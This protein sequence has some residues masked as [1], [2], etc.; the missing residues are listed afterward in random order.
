M[1]NIL[2]NKLASEFSFTLGKYLTNLGFLDE[3]W[4]KN[5]I[6]KIFPKDNEKYWQAA[7]TGYLI[8]PRIYRDIYSLLRENGHYD[9]ALQTKFDD[10]DVTTRLVKHICLGY[11][12]EWEKI[13]DDTSLILKL[14]KRQNTNQLSEIVRFFWKSR[15]ELTDKVKAKIRPLWK[16]LFEL[17]YQKKENP[18]SQKIISNLSR[19]LSLVD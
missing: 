2:S 6:N 12:E 17:M 1:A 10:K 4:V 15:G 19:W 5:N 8:N 14:I 18:D 7:F 3:K 9:K 16:V 13:D 11:V